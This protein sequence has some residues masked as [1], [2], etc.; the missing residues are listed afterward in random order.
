MIA[1]DL[2]S[3][4]MVVI[5]DEDSK[6]RDYISGRVESFL[7]KIRKNEDMR[8]FVHRREE[9]GKTVILIGLDEHESKD[10]IVEAI[11]KRTKKDG[12]GVKVLTKSLKNEKVATELLN[13][14]KEI[15]EI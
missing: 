12:R 1:T 10:A 5:E 13:I 7:S 3:D 9:S 4:I 11:C 8:T 15:S 2:R 6:K 14:A